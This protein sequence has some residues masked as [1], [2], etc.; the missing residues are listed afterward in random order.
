MVWTRSVA[1]AS[2]CHCWKAGKETDTKRSKMIAINN[3][4]CD[5]NAACGIID[6]LTLQRGVKRMIINGSNEKSPKQNLELEKRWH[7]R[8][9]YIDS[10]HWTSH[11]LFA[12]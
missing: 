8:G 12:S 9:S 5:E 11:P 10:G 1:L 3:P 7:E 6:V 4:F 2:L